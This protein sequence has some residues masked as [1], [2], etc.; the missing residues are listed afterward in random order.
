M[1]S[2]LSLFRRE[3]R[4]EA[5]SD[6]LNDLLRKSEQFGKMSLTRLGGGWWARIEMNTNATGATFKIESEYSSGTPQTPLQAV[7]PCTERM[8]AAL[9]TLGV[10]P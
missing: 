7:Q 10:Q 5:K 3:N 6:S 1:M 9:K 2:G 4:D 8:N